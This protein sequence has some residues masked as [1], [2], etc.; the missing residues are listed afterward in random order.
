MKRSIQWLVAASIVLSSCTTSK[1]AD[2]SPSEPYRT[3]EWIQH[4]QEPVPNLF[5]D[6]SEKENV[7]HGFYEQSGCEASSSS[8][9][10]VAHYSYLA[11]RGIRIGNASF[12][13]SISPSGRFL[14][15]PESYYHGAKFYK[16]KIYDKSRN[17]FL[18]RSIPAKTIRGYNW[19][20]DEQ[21]VTVHFEDTDKVISLSI[22]KP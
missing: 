4:S 22:S 17:S 16:L 11:Y 2:E 20:K 13:Y 10:A 12:P 21:A 18:V 8:W 5:G 3:S 9:E 15:I 19:T 6:Q 14:V 7:G 1:R